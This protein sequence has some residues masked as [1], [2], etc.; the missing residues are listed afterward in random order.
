[1][2]RT[3]CLCCGVPSRGLAAS[4]VLEGVPLGVDGLFLA[5]TPFS[6]VLLIFLPFTGVPE[7]V[8]VLEVL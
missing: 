4:F 7:D 1:M 2:E 8:S 3:H 6:F 5:F